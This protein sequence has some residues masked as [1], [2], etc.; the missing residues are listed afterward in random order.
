MS[1]GPIRN[2]LWLKYAIEEETRRS[3]V[4]FRFNLQT[5]VR[6][7][8][9]LPSL[10]ARNDVSRDVCT[11]TFQTSP[12]IRRLQQPRGDQATQRSSVLLVWPGALAGVV[13]LSVTRV[14]IHSFAWD[15][16]ICRYNPDNG[17]IFVR[18]T[19]DLVLFN[20]SVAR[21]LINVIN[22]ALLLFDQSAR[23]M[24][25]PNMHGE[26]HACDGSCIIRCC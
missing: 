1:F 18:P 19:P 26:K 22:A 5:A 17:Y 9:L 25:H 6:S 10:L 3:I 24:E 14:P 21:E 20:W 7:F 16:R 23:I 8:S 15:H 2:T 4:V 13:A 11:S 12:G